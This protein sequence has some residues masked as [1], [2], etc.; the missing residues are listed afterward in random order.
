MKLGRL[1]AQREPA[2]PHVR[3]LALAPAPAVIDR[4]KAVQEW[5]MLQNDI[6]G[7]CT[8][9][10]AGHIM[11]LWN[12][13]MGN[14]NG[15]MTDAEAVDLYSTLSGYVPGDAA[16]DSGLTERAVLRCWDRWGF[17]SGNSTIK[18]SNFYTAA[19]TSLLDAKQAIAHL[20]ALYIGVNLPENAMQ[21]ERWDVEPGAKILGGHAVPLVG[22]DD[23]LQSFYV[24][25][26]GACFPLT[27][28]FFQQYC[29]EAWGLE[30]PDWTPPA[31]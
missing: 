30:C 5:G 14:G 27:Y 21:T 7:D 24:V 18:L 11:L 9:A 4:W 20:G 28:R 26:W 16:T 12:T 2:R 17:P 10:S 6:C 25:S 8:I 31:T 23:G 22:Y 19:P 15:T 3:D 13:V 1:P 29:E